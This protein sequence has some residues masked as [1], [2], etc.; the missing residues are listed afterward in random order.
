MSLFEGVAR[1]ATSS[2][3]AENFN[4]HAGGNQPDCV[5]PSIERGY[6]PRPNACGVDEYGGR[7]YQSGDTT[8]RLPY[9]ILE[10]GDSISTQVGWT[11]EVQR[12]LQRAWPTR[13]VE[14]HTFG[15][16]GYNTCQEVSMYEE[17]VERIQPDLVLLQ[18]CVNDSRDSPVMMHQGS[19]VH[20]FV[21]DKVTDFPAWVLHSR[22]LT[23]VALTI[24]T[25][26]SA[27]L[28][29]KQGEYAEACLT[30]L[31]ELTTRAGLPLR[32]VIFPT[33]WEVADIPVG[34]RTDEQSVEGLHE[35]AGTTALRLRPTL[36]AAGPMEE[37]RSTPSDF[38]HPNP[39]AQKLI[40]TA[41]AKWLVETVPAP[42][43][44]TP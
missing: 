6:T 38:L 26:S 34:M 18:T 24:H 17:Q 10:I 14:L 25:P 13:S 12:G 9:R 33:L 11:A 40:G 30:R 37:H 16:S 35:R 3:E 5:E 7:T 23:L 15:V 44:T 8:T 28:K 27:K 39:T 20:Y 21:G 1:F 4:L 22:F 41:V 2:F 43:T 19:R 29:D 31:R 42:V 36:E 32:V